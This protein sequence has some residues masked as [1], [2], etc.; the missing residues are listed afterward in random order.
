MTCRAAVLLLLLLILV[1]TCA[2]AP[3]YTTEIYVNEPVSGSLNP[4]QSAFYWYNARTDTKSIT[5]TL[6]Y[7][8]LP[9]LPFNESDFMMLG[10]FSTELWQ[11]PMAEANCSAGECVIHVSV[12]KQLLLQ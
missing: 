1:S 2:K 9:S 6:T 8:E 5:F 7:A 11:P 4:G 10:R 3:E 12:R